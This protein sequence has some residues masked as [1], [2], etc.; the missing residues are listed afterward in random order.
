LKEERKAKEKG[1]EPE[2]PQ[3]TFGTGEKIPRGEGEGNKRDFKKHPLPGKEAGADGFCTFSKSMR[4]KVR[5]T[6]ETC[7]RDKSYCGNKHGKKSRG[8]REDRR[9]LLAKL[10]E[11]DTIAG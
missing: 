6:K 9:E 7:G 11:F 4:L 10:L 1:R 5:E 3:G 2:N 8:G